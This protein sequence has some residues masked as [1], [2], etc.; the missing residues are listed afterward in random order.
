M[1][2][3]LSN[4]GSQSECVCVC[5]RA[6]VLTGNAGRDTWLFIFMLRCTSLC[7]CFLEPSLYGGM[8]SLGDTEVTEVNYPIS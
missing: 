4:P 5:V 2:I 7:K 8:E 1:Q 6:C 3:P